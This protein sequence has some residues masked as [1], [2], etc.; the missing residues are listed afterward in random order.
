MAE[1]YRLGRAAGLAVAVATLPAA[2]QA[3]GPTTGV[4]A[5]DSEVLQ[6]WAQESGAVS[7]ELV[8]TS[9]GASRL[10]W[11]G[12]VSTDY[13]KNSSRGGY[14]LTPSRDD[15]SN[16]SVQ[17]QTEGRMSW[18][19]TDTSWLMFGGTASDDR[20]VLDHPAMINTLQLGHAAE[21]YRVMLGD[22]P[23]NFSTLGANTGLRGLQ[24]EVLVG[25]TLM[26]AVAG[27]QSETWEALSKRER[28]T[29]YLRDTYALK[30]QQSLTDSLALYVT[31][32]GYSDDAD[33]T[34]AEFT[35]LAPSDGDATTT[36]F[37]FQQDRFTLSGEVGFSDWEE[38]GFA[39][40]HDDAWILDASWQGERVGLQVGHHDLGVYYTS[41]SGAALSGVRETYGSAN[42]VT[43][44]WLSFNGDLRRTINKRA[45]TPAAVPP[46]ATPYTPNAYE[47]DSWTLGSNFSVLQVPGLSLQLQRSES[48][49]EN[50]D[51][52]DN[53]LD[54]TL[55]N[56]QYNVGGWNTGFGYQRSDVDNSATLGT[57]SNS[58]TRG[59]N[60]LLGRQWFE[61]DNGDWS[62]GVQ[63]IYSDQR[64][65]L[66]A[67]GRT[68]N[69]NYQ[70]AVN[71][72]HI[73]W[74]QLAVVWFDGRVQDTETGQSLDQWQLQVQAERSLG[75]FGSVK[76]YFSKNDS[77]EEKAAIA[78]EEKL[79][80][81][82]FMSAFG[83]D[84]DDR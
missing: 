29:R 35:A 31:N 48:N 19:E 11:R 2:V 23:V 61:P 45:E 41:V 74:G 68:G 70:L 69:E 84:F 79:V 30:V 47:A 18:N 73:R 14:T 7:P 15:N 32:Q 21:N 77:F 66:D 53:D 22:L 9:D 67:G 16:Y 5:P 57:N 40:E 51:G 43:N 55:F 56:V 60:Y 28:R 58:V 50:E 20:S 8:R 39:D 81:L 6:L 78:Y 83:D 24:G 71:A 59:W 46:S 3:A 38:E 49:G 34:T 33:S 10:Q 17:L 26:Q 37:S 75:R 54:D 80:G 52:G 36:G 13:Y 42:W 72:Q 1:R 4:V 27:V 82:Q 65:S 25:R 64:Q 44:D 76:L 63:G 62:V 12:A